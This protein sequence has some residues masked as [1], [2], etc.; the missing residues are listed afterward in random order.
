[1]F[2]YNVE[3]WDEMDNKV[4][5]EKGIIGAETYGSAADKLVE[6]YG[7]DNI[8]TIELSE[9]E[10]VMADVDLREEIGNE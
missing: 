5:K 8:F 2:R 4:N 10:S 6:Y 7:A 1:M 9:I 3:F